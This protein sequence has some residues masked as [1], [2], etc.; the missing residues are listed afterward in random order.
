MT[1]SSLSYS[2]A[3]LRTRRRGTALDADALDGLYR[4]HSRQLL[5]YFARRT[6][7]ADTATDLVAETFAAAFRDRRQFRG[8][9]G[10]E[11]AA[12]LFGIARHQLA[13]Y[14]RRGSVERDAM[15]RLVLERRGLSDEELERIEEL[16]GIAALRARV[17]DRVQELDPRDQE[18]LRLRVVE[19]RGYEE[20]AAALAVGEDAVRARVSRALKRLRALVEERDDPDAL[21]LAA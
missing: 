15:R 14:Y 6:I 8:R 5:I 9:T 1:P 11:A 2:L 3:L 4:A 10:D 21:E 13:S 19:E 12:W 18:I 20:I 16:A 17:R 7:D